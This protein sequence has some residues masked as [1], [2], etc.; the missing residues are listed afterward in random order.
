MRLLRAQQDE[1]GLTA[2]LPPEEEESSEETEE[3]A[4]PTVPASAVSAKKKKKNKKNKS[5]KKL[6]PARDSCLYSFVPPHTGTKENVGWCHC[7]FRIFYGLHVQ[8][9]SMMA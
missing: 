3:A 6:A 1:F 5:K 7:L 8:Y 4:F 9:Y 2:G